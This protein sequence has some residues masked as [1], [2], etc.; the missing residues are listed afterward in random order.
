L[1]KERVTDKEAICLFIAFVIGSSLIVGTGSGAKNDAWLAVI[2]GILMV[3]PIMLVYCRILAISGGENFFEILEHTLGKAL[4][5]IIAILY[6]LYAFHLG[7]LV[8]RNFGEFIND[9]ALPETPILLPMLFI[10]STC[11]I[12]ARLGIEVMGRTTA[13]FLPIIF[14]SLLA[15]QLLSI[16]G[17]KLSY[18]KPVLGNGIGPVISAGFD[19]FSYPFAE[20]ALLMGAFSG[21]KTKKSPYR[22]YFWG[23]LIVGVIVI[24]ATV[25][26]IAVLGNM[27]DSFYFPSYAAVSS[28]KIGD[29]IQRIEVTVSFVFVFGVLI[30]TSICLVAASKGISKIFNLRDYRSIVIQI[31]LLMTFFAFTVYN[32]SLEMRYWTTRVYPYYAFPMQVILPV[33]I[34]I[35]AEIKA[36]RRKAKKSA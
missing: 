36:K 17:L 16:P 12:A 4:G 35:F 7:A 27:L 22:I 14:F 13:Y 8:L 31:G 20:T 2:T 26:N 25:R 33:I 10:G 23:L 21:L 18:V 11:I 34:W 19:T 30:K 28:I 32:N 6:C 15:V 5:K 9:V 1:K 29:F 3:I 24:I